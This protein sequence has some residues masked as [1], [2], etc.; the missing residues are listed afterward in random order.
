MSTALVRTA[1]SR[2]RA[3]FGPA[4]SQPRR[5]SRVVIVGG[6]AGGLELAIR[7]AKLTRPGDRA[8]VTLIDRRLTHIWKPRLHEIA[9]GLLV[10]AQEEAGYAA[11]GRRHGFDFVLGEVTRLDPE[12]RRI[13]IGPT[14]YPADDPVAHATGDDLLPSRTLDYD[15]AVLAIGSTVNDSGVPGVRER[16]Y[17]LTVQSRRNGCTTPFWRAPR[18]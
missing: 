4:Q 1:A 11:Q 8:R 15:T 7:L 16:W 18:A 9:A 2:A 17:T 10:A 14:S 12:H 13:E 6:G 5:S 3:G